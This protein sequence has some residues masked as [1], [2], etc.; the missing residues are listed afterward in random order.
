MTNKLDEQL[1]TLSF[2]EPS[3]NYQNNVLNI[4]TSSK[5][6]IWLKNWNFAL[7]FLL[8]VSISINL[9]QNSN[10]NLVANTAQIASQTEENQQPKHTIAYGATAPG[11]IKSSIVQT[12][13][14]HQ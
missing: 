7:I 14:T 5:K 2:V 9:L 13:E 3:A 8:V 10:S 6:I 1:E 12:W 4:L 11:I